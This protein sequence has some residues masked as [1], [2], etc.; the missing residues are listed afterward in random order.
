MWN[1]CW[2][3][4]CASVRYSCFEEDSMI[5][6]SSFQN[7]PDFPAVFAQEQKTEASYE[8]EQWDHVSQA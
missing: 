6:A 2:V 3:D 7:Q 4:L 1:Q 8:T 5:L